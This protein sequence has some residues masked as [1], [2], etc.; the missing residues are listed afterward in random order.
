[1]WW[2]LQKQWRNYLNLLQTTFRCGALY[3]KDFKGYNRRRDWVRWKRIK[4]TH[5]LEH[6]LQDLSR[7]EDRP[8]AQVRCHPQASWLSLFTDRW[9]EIPCHLTG[10]SEE[11]TLTLQTRVVTRPLFLQIMETNTS[12]PWDTS[13]YNKYDPVFA[14]KKTY[15]SNS[16]CTYFSCFKRNP[17]D[18]DLCPCITLIFTLDQPL[19]ILS[20]KH[21]KENLRYQVENSLI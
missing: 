5:L 12:K 4:A 3:W 16:H 10:S 7:Y 15:M 14:K 1:M 13:W 18:R 19:A 6:I 2:I 8:T 9:W 21:T 11:G 20:T 17:S